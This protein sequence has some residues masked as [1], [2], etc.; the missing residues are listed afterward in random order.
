MPES[1]FLI[2]KKLALMFRARTN[3]R[4][5]SGQDICFNVWSK[6]NQR[7]GSGQGGNINAREWFLN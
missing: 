4:R 7:L 5:S 2:S 1:G 3:Q 6:N